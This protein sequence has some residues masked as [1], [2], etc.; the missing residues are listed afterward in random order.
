[1]PVVVNGAIVID[2][3]IGIATGPLGGT[4]GNVIAMTNSEGSGSMLPTNARTADI[5]EVYRRLQQYQGSSSVVA[6]QRLH[7][8]KQALGIPAN[9]NLLFD[10]TGN[11]YDPATSELLFSLTGSI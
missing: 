3:T 5:Q 7:E 1:V 6:S 9:A 11:V 4:P 2:A 10:M 8:G